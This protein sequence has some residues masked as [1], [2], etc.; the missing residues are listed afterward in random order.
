MKYNFNLTE[1]QE[2]IVDSVKQ[3]ADNR[4]WSNRTRFEK[5]DYGLVPELLKEAAEYGFIG[6]SI[7]Y[8]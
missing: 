2:F 3:F 4:L 8:L 5:K 6:A 1:E 7:R